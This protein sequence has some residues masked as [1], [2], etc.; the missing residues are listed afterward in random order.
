MK[1]EEPNKEQSKETKI[2]LA[3]FEQRVVILPPAA[4]NFGGIEAVSGKILFQRGPNS[5]SADK[6][7][8]TLQL[9]MTVDPKAEW[10][11]IF[12][13]VW[14]IERDFFY[15]PNMHDV[16]WELA[17]GAYRIKEIVADAGGRLKG[18]RGDAHGRDAAPEPRVD[19]IQP[20]ARGRSV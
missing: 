6:K 18:R 20:E 7:R 1:K 15:D 4:G 13:D 14:R 5:G 11:Q 3:G 19:R 10:K 2:T 16:D 9:E 8:P 12:T 17:N